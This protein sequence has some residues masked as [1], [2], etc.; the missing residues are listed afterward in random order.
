MFFSL[1]DSSFPAV[2]SFPFGVCPRSPLPWHWVGKLRRFFLEDCTK[3]TS[4]MFAFPWLAWCCGQQGTVQA[5]QVGRPMEVPVSQPHTF[6]GLTG[7]C[8]S[9]QSRE[10]TPFC[11]S[12]AHPPGSTRRGGASSTAVYFFSKQYIWNSKKKSYGNKGGGFKENYRGL[13]KVSVGQKVA[14]WCFERIRGLTHSRHSQFGVCPDPEGL[15]VTGLMCTGLRG[16]SV[17]LKPG[18]ELPLPWGTPPVSAHWFC[19]CQ[20]TP[21]LFYVASKFWDSQKLQLLSTTKNINVVIDHVRLC[22]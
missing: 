15:H 20:G 13:W 16:L 19:C 9:S 3:G 1:L 17:L 10:L 22:L 12:P 11:T 14:S 5:S 6:N 7:G 2:L 4:D 21:E 18:V 8:L